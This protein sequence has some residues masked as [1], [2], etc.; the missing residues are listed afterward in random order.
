MNRV[1]NFIVFLLCQIAV[2]LVSLDNK[3]F[4]Q[5][6]VIESVATLFVAI[7]YFIVEQQKK[8]RKSKSGDKKYKN[9]NY[10]HPRTS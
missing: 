1:L 3:H 9:V 6:V 10:R 2:V 5:I 4:V 8:H 7:Q